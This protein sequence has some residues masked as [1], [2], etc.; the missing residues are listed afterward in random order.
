MTLDNEGVRCKTAPDCAICRSTGHLLY[1]G[2]RDRLFGAPGEW[3]LFRCSGPACGLVWSSPVPLPSEI[4]KLYRSYYTHSDAEPVSVQRSSRIKRTLALINFWRKP[5]FL[6]ANIHLESLRP[7]RLLEIGCG[8]GALLEQAAKVGWIAMGIDF[9]EAAV[10]R[11][12]EREGVSAHLGELQQRTFADASFDAIVMN[13]VIEHIWNP[14]DTMR[15]CRRVLKPSGRMIIVTPNID[16]I[17]HRMF[18]RH[19]RGLEPPRHLFIYNVRSLKRLVKLCGFRHPLVFTSSGG[20]G[21]VSMLQASQE[22]AN[23]ELSP[24]RLRRIIKQETAASYLG[25][26][27]GEWCVAVC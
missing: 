23:G 21:G 8:N 3:T 22:A 25:F 4:A 17:G 2:L 14:V 6:T 5:M 19:W 12:N 26:H 15:E 1:H 9:D 10:A 13:N 7:G 20:G 18:G 16:S 24:S 11:A 27:I